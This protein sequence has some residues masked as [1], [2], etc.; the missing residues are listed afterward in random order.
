MKIQWNVVVHSFLSLLV[1]L[2]LTLVAWVFR[3][4]LIPSNVLLIYLLGVFFVAIQFGLFSSVL[5]SLISAAAFAFFFAPPIFSLKIA[6][7]DN[8][9]GLVIMLKPKYQMK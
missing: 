4:I 6:D 7:F 5:A 1:L 3:D 8:L 2:V 9:M